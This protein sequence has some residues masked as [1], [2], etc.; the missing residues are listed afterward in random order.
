MNSFL[1]RLGLV[2]AKRR[3]LTLGVWVAVVA[4]I[5]LGLALYRMFFLF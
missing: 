3:W 4:A 1:Y 5:L 2:A